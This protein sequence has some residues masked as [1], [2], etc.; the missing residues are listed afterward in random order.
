MG[1]ALHASVDGAAAARQRGGLSD[2]ISPLVSFGA[3]WERSRYA[4][5]SR[6]LGGEVKRWGGELT[7]ANLA[8]LRYGHVDDP[9][10][11]IQGDTW[12]LGLGV[13]YRNA[14]GIRYDF[15]SVPQSKYLASHVDRHGVTAFVD[16][17]RLWAKLR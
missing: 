3:T 9:V 10:G 15:A 16:P 4:W 17:L 11:T 6:D 2:L 7:L 13:T 8:S 12:G 14:V 1:F 5:H